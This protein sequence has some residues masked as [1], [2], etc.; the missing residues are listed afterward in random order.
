MLA[1][2]T[3]SRLLACKTRGSAI[4]VA[5][6]LCSRLKGKTWTTTL[7]NEGLAQEYRCSTY[8]CPRRRPW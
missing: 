5:D 1:E 3:C 7:V 8:R 2:I 4:G 6:A